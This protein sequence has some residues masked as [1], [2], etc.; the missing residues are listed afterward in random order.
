MIWLTWRQ[1][2]KQLLYAVI[3][4]AALAAVIV[5]T[6]LAMRHTFT[7]SGL[8]ACLDKIGTGTYAVSSGD[9]ETLNQ[10]FSKQYGAMN[11]V[12]ILFVVLPLLVGLF[13][14]AALIARETEHGTHRFVWTQGVSRMR[15]GLTKGG[16][17]GAAAIV[18]AV[19]Y[20][21]GVSWWFAPLAAVD[22]NGRLGYLIFDVQGIAPIG[23]T[24]FALALGIFAST[25]WHRMMPAMGVTLAGFV[26][27]RVL[28]ETLARP[29]YMTPETATSPIT[30]TRELNEFSGNWISAQGV[31]NAKGTLV[32]PNGGMHCPSAGGTHGQPSCSHELVQ[33]GLGPGPFS[34]W[35]QYQPA[36]RFWAFQGIEV[37]IFV[38]LAALLLYV[39]IRRLRRIS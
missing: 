25:V 1:H 5:P 13:F 28:V 29:H 14:G 19:G 33:Q 11:F 31:V 2:R 26:V 18:L 12:S 16:L 15:W 20:A 23:Y 32:V 36:D 8:A 35:E 10:Q 7:S 17:V 37:G 30:S 24:L 21:L 38:V 3:A 6:G 4:L 9:C 27:V 39:A 34:N 22:G